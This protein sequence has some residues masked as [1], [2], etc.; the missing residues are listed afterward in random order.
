LGA[1]REAKRLNQNNARIT[2]GIFPALFPSSIYACVYSFPAER[3]K[4][5]N[6]RIVVIFPDRIYRLK[7]AIES[8][9]LNV[10]KKVTGIVDIVA[11]RVTRI[12]V[13]FS[14][15]NTT[16]TQLTIC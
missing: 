11:G 12:F 5:K 9:Q 8:K 1:L 2:M 7:M 13:R 4:F 6:I 10:T 3:F 14:N 15:C 16:K